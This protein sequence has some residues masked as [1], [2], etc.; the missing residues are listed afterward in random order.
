M[1]DTQL[2]KWVAS[3]LIRFGLGFGH[4]ELEYIDDAGLT[5]MVRFVADKDNPM[6]VEVLKGCIE[7]ANGDIYKCSIE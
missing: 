7:T 6:D 2:L 5:H 3:H 4:G 1:N